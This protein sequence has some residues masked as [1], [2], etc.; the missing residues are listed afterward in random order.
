M[1][2]GILLSMVIGQYS[3]TNDMGSLGGKDGDFSA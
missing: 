1:N 3:A 2:L